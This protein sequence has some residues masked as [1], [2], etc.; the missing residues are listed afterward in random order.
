MSRVQRI[1]NEWNAFVVSFPSSSSS[2]KKNWGSSPR[3]TAALLLQRDFNEG[4]EDELPDFRSLTLLTKSESSLLGRLF[5]YSPPCLDPWEYF[6]ITTHLLS[7][8]KF[9]K[10]CKYNFCRIDHTCLWSTYKSALVN[11]S[12]LELTW[13][14]LDPG[15][16][17]T[18][19]VKLSQL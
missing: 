1:G 19:Q 11:L 4:P 13:V 10:R 8:T 14:N 9:S 2:S 6:G 7:K 12:H 3:A 15:Q 5:H 18:T 17:E 16:L